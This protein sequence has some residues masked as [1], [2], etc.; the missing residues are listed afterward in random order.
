MKQSR[1]NP[2]KLFE[3]LV[4]N[5]DSKMDI[6]CKAMLVALCVYANNISLKQNQASLTPYPALLK[7]LTGLSS[8][9]ICRAKRELYK[10][11]L[12]KFKS[13]Y[14]RQSSTLLPFLKKKKYKV[15]QQTSYGLLNLP[16]FP[17]S[18]IENNGNYSS[19]L[20]MLFKKQQK[21]INASAAFYFMNNYYNN[22]GLKIKLNTTELVLLTALVALNDAQGWVRPFVAKLESICQI[23]SIS[24]T[25]FFKLRRKLEQLGLIRLQ[26]TQ[27]QTYS[28]FL[29]DNVV[30]NKNC[31]LSFKS[32]LK[33]VDNFS[34][35]QNNTGYQSLCE[36]TTVGS[37]N[38]DQM[39]TNVDNYMFNDDKL[40][41]L[42]Q[43]TSATSSN[44]FIITN[45][46]L[47]KRQNT[48]TPVNL[49]E[50][51]SKSNQRK[52]WINNKI[53]A[54]LKK[55][56][57][58]SQYYYFYKFKIEEII[59]RRLN[60]L[61]MIVKELLAKGDY[62]RIPAIQQKYRIN[63]YDNYVKSIIVRWNRVGFDD[64]PNFI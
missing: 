27:K 45:K 29:A 2:F 61:D 15:K 17:L 18:K 60:K 14:V 64:I 19:E 43:S 57:V 33:A 9:S 30:N 59:F 1:I 5:K 25:Q 54:N 16:Q 7:R 26:S 8:S 40:S 11:Q 10:A 44:N 31:D 22:F 13:T 34:S 47:L 49:Q 62:L 41:N 63:D 36:N 28:I 38:D 52:E 21:P 4:N 46:G 51:I 6:K 32:Q 48:T 58:T 12:I 20:I 53:D 50:I 3:Y 37:V 24:R 23:S 35:L 56:Q 39:R 42:D 55:M